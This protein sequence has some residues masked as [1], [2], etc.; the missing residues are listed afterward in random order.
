MESSAFSYQKFVQFA[1]QEAQSF[2]SLLPLPLPVSWFFFLSS[3]LLFFYG[4]K[5]SA[6]STYFNG[7]PI[8]LMFFL[9][10]LI[11]SIDLCEFGLLDV[12][13]FLSLLSNHVIDL[14][15]QNARISRSTTR[16]KS[17]H[18]R[19]IDYLYMS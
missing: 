12:Q 1:V 18:T 9:Y 4:S 5:L 3:K 16:W 19:Q 10:S 7:Y 17:A 14:E 2:T 6:F 15:I 13:S 11:L 8:L